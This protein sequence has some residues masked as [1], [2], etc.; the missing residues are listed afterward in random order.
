MSVAEVEE[1]LPLEALDPH[2]IDLPGSY[3]RRIIPCTHEKR[4]E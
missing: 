1:T 3:R 4:I 2:L